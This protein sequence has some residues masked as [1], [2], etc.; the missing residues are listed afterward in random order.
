ML[1]DPAVLRP[2]PGAD[3]IAYLAP[4]AA[5][6][7]NTEVGAFTYVHDPEDP[8]RF[9]ETRVHHHYDHM[10]DRLIIGRFCA[11]AEGAA[12]VMNGANHIA[13]GV[14][15]YPFEIFPG[16]EAEADQARWSDVSRGDT[17]VGHDVWIGAHATILPGVTVGSGAI[18]GTHAVVGA[19][20]APYTVMAGNP[21]RPVRQRFAADVVDRLLRVAWWD[22]PIQRIKRNL[23]AIRAADI[24]KLESA[25]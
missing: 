19:D 18:I 21:A 20:V 25:P 4:I 3:S 9:F 1:P 14:S 15:T 10:G 7:P 5:G 16:W 17:V 2:V 11:I 23:A 8:A 6:R 22:W 24:D 13:D 12:F